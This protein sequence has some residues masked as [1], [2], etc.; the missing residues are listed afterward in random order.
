MFESGI[1]CDAEG[2]DILRLKQIKKILGSTEGLVCLAVGGSGALQ[3]M[4]RHSNGGQWLSVAWDRSD[5]ASLSAA[6]QTD[7]WD[8]TTGHLPFKDGSLDLVVIL[9]GLEDVKEDGDLITDCHRVLKGNGRLLINVRL[10]KKWS[11]LPINRHIYTVRQGYTETQL[12]RILKD[13]FDVKQVASYGKLFTELALHFRWNKKIFLI[14]S[15]LDHLLFFARAYNFLA[16]A[17][18]RPW[19]PRRIPVL[20]DGRSIAEAALQSKIGTAFEF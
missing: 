19:R 2:I 4:L 3:S 5:V 20:N 18:C 12:F 1:Q 14:A 9:E 7:V 13:G 15:Y 17:K 11:L 10:Y 8:L 16:I 6:L